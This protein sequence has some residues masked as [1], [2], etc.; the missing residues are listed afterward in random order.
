MFDWKYA[1]GITAI[2]YYLLKYYSMCTNIQ[3]QITWDTF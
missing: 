2:Q 3:P 1:A